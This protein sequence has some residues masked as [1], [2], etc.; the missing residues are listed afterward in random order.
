[1]QW[2][3]RDL[4]RSRGLCWRARAHRDNSSRPVALAMILMIVSRHQT[5]IQTGANPLDLR[6]YESSCKLDERCDN[7]SGI[8][9][10]VA[11]IS[12]NRLTNGS[13]VGMDLHWQ[14]G[15]RHAR[16]SRLKIEEAKV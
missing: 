13:G 12:S 9:H 15:P 1:M 4:P 3:P 8:G 7:I 6:S 2:R 16:S 5:L 11:H 14:P 10:A